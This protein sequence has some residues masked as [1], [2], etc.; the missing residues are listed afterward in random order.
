MLTNMPIYA[1]IVT[2]LPNLLYGRPK[3]RTRRGRGRNTRIA[4]APA[5][6]W[7]WATFFAAIPY[8]A[9]RAVISRLVMKSL[10]VVPAGSAATI[11]R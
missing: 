11:L 4:Q 8:R 1:K 9:F 7:L 5:L 2:K 6:P 3:L 10:G